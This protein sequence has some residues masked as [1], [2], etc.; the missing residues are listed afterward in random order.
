M[1][2]SIS[3]NSL[4]HGGSSTG[5]ASGAGV[6][7]TRPLDKCKT[8]LFLVIHLSFAAFGELHLLAIFVANFAQI[9]AELV[10]IV[11]ASVANRLA[12]R[13][14]FIDQRILC[15]MALFSSAH[16]QPPTIDPA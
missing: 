12:Y 14:H 9:F 7:A 6:P 11:V 5:K 8:Q 3:T 1:G 13:S 15:F 4:S 2:R 10:E 16:R